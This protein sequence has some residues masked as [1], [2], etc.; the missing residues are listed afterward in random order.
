MFLSIICVSSQTSEFRQ[1]IEMKAIR[2]AVALLACAAFLQAAAQ[3]QT[4]AFG[5]LELPQSSHEAALGGRNVSIIGQDPAM[6]FSNPATLSY[7]DRR[8]LGLNV[9]TWMAGT[10]AAGACYCDAVG[11]RSAFGVTARY[12]SYG[13]SDLTDKSGNASGTFSSRDIAIAGSYSY[14]LGDRLSGG[15]TLRALYS[16]Y[17]FYSSFSMSV[18]LG[19]SYTDY[20]GRFTAGLSFTNMGGQIKPFENTREKLPFDITAGF[21][22][23]LEHAPIRLSLTLDRLNRW[24]SSDFYSP[25]GN[26]SGGDIFARHITIGADI[27]FTDRIYAA[28]GYN[29]RRAAELSTGSHRGLTGMTIG[30]GVNLNRMSFGIAFG[31]FQV[32]TSSLVFNFAINI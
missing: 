28:L 16:K 18:D 13:V 8:Q 31:K 25:D 2:T 10:T 12:V 11:Q 9:T 14:R 20:S 24:D 30:G 3:N 21:S 22:V 7:T 15:T 23:R 6:S 27:L 19:L 17:S 4:S 1:Q 5:F 32:S 29:F 26:L